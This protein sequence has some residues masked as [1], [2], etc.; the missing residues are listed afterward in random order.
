MNNLLSYQMRCFDMKHISVVL[1]DRSRINIQYFSN[2]LQKILNQWTIK[3]TMTKQMMMN[4]KTVW[5]LH[6]IFLRYLCIY[7]KIYSFN[8]SKRSFSTKKLDRLGSL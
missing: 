2:K 6:S 4:L 3:Q 1:L 7:N 8:W 5:Y